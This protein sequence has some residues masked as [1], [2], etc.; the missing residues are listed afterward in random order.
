[1]EKFNK[2]NLGRTVL[3]YYLY[4]CYTNTLFTFI[5]I[6]C[7][8]LLVTANVNLPMRQLYAWVLFQS[9]LT[10]GSRTFKV[11]FSNWFSTSNRNRVAL[12]SPH[13]NQWNQLKIKL[14]LHQMRL[15]C[16]YSTNFRLMQLQLSQFPR[17]PKNSTPIIFQ[18]SQK[19][20]PFA[21]VGRQSVTKSS[22]D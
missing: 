22:P 12:S 18:Q 9:N 21:A 15:L 5:T 13:V 1:M 11:F 7:I 8:V 4:S 10:C 3:T 16:L 17:N 14:G 2:C 20:F 6:H 19:H